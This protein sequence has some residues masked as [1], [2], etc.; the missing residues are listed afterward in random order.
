MECVKGPNLGY[1]RCMTVIAIGRALPLELENL[2]GGFLGSY[3]PKR[4]APVNDL[5]TPRASAMTFHGRIG[6]ANKHE[7]NNH[8]G[9][10]TSCSDL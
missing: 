10:W 3:E 7:P 4:K 8:V 1:C 9:W 5:A 6:I 2:I